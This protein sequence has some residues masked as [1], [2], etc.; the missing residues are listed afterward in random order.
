M[1]KVRIILLTC[2]INKNNIL[3]S[4]KSK[5]KRQTRELRTCAQTHNFLKGLH[6][7]ADHI[8]H[9]RDQNMSICRRKSQEKQ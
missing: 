4:C 3:R 2:D 7:K 8:G 9:L 6:L 5:K 1:S